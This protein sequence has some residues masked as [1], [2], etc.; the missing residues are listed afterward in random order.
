M[1]VEYSLLDKNQQ[2]FEIIPSEWN[3]IPEIVFLATKS[4]IEYLN[5]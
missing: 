2:I 1:S 4:I 5:E 3:N